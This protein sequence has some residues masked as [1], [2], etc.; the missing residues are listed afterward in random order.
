MSF[1]REMELNTGWK[2]MVADDAQVKTEITSSAEWSFGTI[3]DAQVPGEWPLDYV[4][5]GLLEDPFF[6]DNYLKLRDYEHSH[7]YYSVR[8]RWQDEPDELTFLRFEGID[9]VADLYLNGQKI[10][11][12]ENMFIPHEFAADGL[13]HGFQLPAHEG[14]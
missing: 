13:V 11:H 2:L 12:A 14:C 8:F 4:R 1:A 5:H 10:G 9:T 6:G 7:V 3:L